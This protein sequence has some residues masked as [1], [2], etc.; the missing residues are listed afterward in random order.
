MCVINPDSILKETYLFL[1]VLVYTK[2][3]NKARINQCDYSHQLL[4][5]GNMFTEMHGWVILSIMQTLQNV[6][7]Q[8]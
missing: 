1:A 4:K 8:I 6:H 3:E 5:D 2:R 7:T